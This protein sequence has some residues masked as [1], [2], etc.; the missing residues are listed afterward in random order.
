[1]ITKDNFKEIIYSFPAEQ[2]E[3]IANDGKDFV[4]LEAF[5]F[6]TGV[7]CSIESL[8]YS[9]AVDIEANENGQLF[10]DKDRFYMLLQEV[11]I[12]V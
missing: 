12:E 10:C 7:K 1:M 6:N 4:L 3:E 5:I 2:I 11:G 8:D 9:E